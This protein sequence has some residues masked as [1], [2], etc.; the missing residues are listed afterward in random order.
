MHIGSQL[1]PVPQPSHNPVRDIHLDLN[2]LAF[3][4]AVALLDFS[5]EFETVRL[6]AYRIIVAGGVSLGFLFQEVGDADLHVLVSLDHFYF[7]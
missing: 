5:W 6:I 3:L 2:R 1:H 7:E 4:K